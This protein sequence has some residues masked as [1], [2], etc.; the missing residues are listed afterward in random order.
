MTWAFPMPMLATGWH[1]A[2]QQCAITHLEHRLASYQHCHLAHLQDMR[3]V[4]TL[5]CHCPALF[6]S[7]RQG[8]GKHVRR[9]GR[10]ERQGGR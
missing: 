2:Q 8:R 3:S 1:E 10:E 5:S 7:G 6:S 4:C 9:H